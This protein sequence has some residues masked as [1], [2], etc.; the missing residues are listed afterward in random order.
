MFFFKRSTI[1]V[2][3]FTT[4][5][6][7]HE[8]Y[9]IQPSI[10][11][12]PEEIKQLQNTYVEEDPNTKIRYSVPTVRKCLG[13]I[14]LYKV[15]HIIPMWTDFFCEPKRSLTNECAPGMMQN[16]FMF[17]MHDN[18]QF[19][20]L[21]LDHIHLKF[22]GVWAIRDKSG[23]KFHWTSPL[24]NQSKHYN[25]FLLLPAVVSYEHQSQTNVNF[26][27]NKKSDDFL[28]KSGTPLVHLTPLTDKKVVFK[29]HLVDMKEYQKIGIPDDYGSFRPDRYK[30]WVREKDKQVKCPFGFGK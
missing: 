28:L 4:H 5:R 8:L 26:F 17:S 19:P 16:P 25:N 11:F 7:V 12:F 10:Q 23:T 20:G 3:S 15:G 24:W 21:F 9:S 18:R 1:V 27:I 14:D 22:H 13:M 30:R 2:D 29:N 6:S